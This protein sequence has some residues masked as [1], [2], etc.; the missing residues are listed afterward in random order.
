M[1][2]ETYWC[3]PVKLVNADLG[4]AVNQIIE[5]VA[6][7][8]DFLIQFRASGGSAELF[9]GISVEA[10]CGE[11]LPSEQLLELGRLG[12]DLALD[13]YAPDHSK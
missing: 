6:P 7:D 8:R 12:L 1:R 5:I 3:Y 13:F 11:M 4:D 9:L 10:N 2:S